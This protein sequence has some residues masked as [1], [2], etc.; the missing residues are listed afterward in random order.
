MLLQLFTELHQRLL[1]K[2][3]QR[4]QLVLAHLQDL[5]DLGDL[6][7]LQTV[8]GALRELELLDRHVEDARRHGASAE[9]LLVGSALLLLQ[10]LEQRKLVDQDVGGLHQGGH[11]RDRAVG[12]HVDDQAVQ[13]G[14][15][16]NTC[17]LDGVV[18]TPNRC[19]DCVDGDHAQRD[20]LAAV[21]GQVADTPLDGQLHVQPRVRRVERGDV[22]LGIGD[23]DLRRVDEIRGGYHARP[24]RL[25]AQRDL[26]I[27]V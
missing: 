5:A 9:A 18:D 3:A 22:Q 6:R 20:G 14:A 15:G 23:L 7:A 11:G 4:Q 1:A 21:R 12:L 8:V 16:A 2:V 10:L 25:Q 26:L 13:V 27:A 24:L 17:A 19:E